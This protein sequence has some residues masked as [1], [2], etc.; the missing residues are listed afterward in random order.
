M[1]FFSEILGIPGMTAITCFVLGASLL[2]APRRMVVLLADAFAFRPDLTVHGGIK[3]L[4]A[5]LYGVGLIGFGVFLGM[6]VLTLA[7]AIF[8]R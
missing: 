8:A 5:R 3:N 7:E 4:I 1:K 6:N 2:A